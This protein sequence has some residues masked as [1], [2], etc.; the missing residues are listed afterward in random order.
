[1]PQLPNALVPDD[2]VA[3]EKSARAALSRQ[4]DHRR[5]RRYR[6]SCSSHQGREDREYYHWAPK[7]GRRTEARKRVEGEIHLV[8]A[9]CDESAGYLRECGARTVEGPA[10]HQGPPARHR[11]TGDPKGFWGREAFYRCS[12]PGG[13]LVW[14]HHR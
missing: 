1:M 2:E 6:H 11:P 10:D 12:V 4:S 9:A 8:L 5:H 7:R 3:V 13:V 14:Q